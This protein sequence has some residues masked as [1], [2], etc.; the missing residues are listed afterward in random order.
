MFRCDNGSTMLI[1]P[2]FRGRILLL[3]SLA[4]ALTILSAAAAIRDP[5]LYQGVM[6]DSLVIGSL[7]FD[8]VSVLAAAALLGCVWAIRRGQERFWLVWV[9]LT[10]H[11]FYAYALYGFGLV[12]NFLYLVYLA[13]LGLAAY[14]LILFGAGL[15]RPLVRDWVPPRLPRQALGAVLLAVVTMF[16]IAWLMMLLPA[17]GRRS[18]L[19]AGTVIAL[20]LALALP[21]LVVVAVLLFRGRPLGDLLAPGAFVMIAAVTLGVGAAEFVRPYFGQAPD[22]RMAGAYFLPTVI[23]GA[24]GMLAF[25]RVGAALR[26]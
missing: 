10:A 16:A 25:R 17:L 21:A 4:A 22:L 1:E 8:V 15:H 13:V 23:S 7:G 6:A 20:D 12:Y 3:S 5:A 26:R 9:G 2:S 18:S 19:P 24:C 11:L 14:S